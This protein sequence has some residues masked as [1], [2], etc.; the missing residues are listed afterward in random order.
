MTGVVIYVGC[1]HI[2]VPDVNWSYA[3]AGWLLYLA[4]EPAAKLIKCSGY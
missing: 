1:E 3:A 4:W 2:A